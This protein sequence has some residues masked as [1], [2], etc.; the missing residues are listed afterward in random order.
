MKEDIKKQVIDN[1]GILFKKGDEPIILDE[2]ED[3]ME[4][5]F[6]T[7]NRSEEN[8]SCLIPYIKKAVRASYLCRGTEGLKSLSQA[9]KSVSLENIEKTLA[10]SIIKAGLRLLP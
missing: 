1:L 10:E 7:S 2:I 3:M 6:S 9:G 4:I 8:G 5:A